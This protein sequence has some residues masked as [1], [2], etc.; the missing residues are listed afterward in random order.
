[1]KMIVLAAML[2]ASCASAAFAAPHC[3]G[4][5]KST[6]GPSNASCAIAK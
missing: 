2:F 3:N 5:Y 1:M 4:D 6:G